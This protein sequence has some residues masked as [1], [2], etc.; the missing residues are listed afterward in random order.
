ML[1]KQLEKKSAFLLALFFIFTYLVPLN[2]RLLWQPDETR[3]AEISREMLQ[4]GNWIVPYL[5]NIRYFEKPVAGYWINNISQ[6]IFGDTNFAVRFGSVFTTIISAGLIYWL[7]MIIWRNKNISFVAT[8]IY[9][10]MFLVFSIGTYSV[11][12]PIFTM[13]LTACMVCCF[14][15]LKTSTLFSKL[16]VWAV[17][18]FTC[19][20]AFMTKGFLG[21]V[22]PVIVMLP[23]MIH[24]KRFI[25]TIKFGSISII[26]ASLTIFPWVLIINKYEPDYWYYFLWVEHIHRFL[27]ENAQHKAPFWF[28]IPII[29]FGVIPW[30]GLLPGTLFKSW[31]KRK[32]NPEM[33]FLLCW[34]ILPFLFFSMAKGKLLTYILPVMAPLALMMAKY[35][36]DCLKDCNLIAFKFNGFINIVFGMLAMIIFIIKLLFIDYP[37]YNSTEWP[38]ICL[39]ISVFF[40][41]LIIGYF[42]MISNVKYWLLGAACSLPL[43]L[44]ISYALPEN[45]IDFKLPQKLIRQNIS[46]LKKSKFILVNNVGLGTSLAW[47]LHRSDIYLY[48]KSGELRYGLNYLDSKFRL[49]KQKKFSNWLR[50]SRKEGQISLVLLLNR[51]EN[52][53]NNIP[54]YDN[55]I[56]NSRIAIITYYY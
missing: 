39:G 25:E 1:T 15:L 35:S 29:L 46:L 17:M 38:K 37:L 16:F 26:S 42:S 28:Y 34:F 49:I 53:P 52:L 19:G 5:L 21:L 27:S 20:M 11:L 33:F 51:N 22:I 4:R 55:V 6:M 44:S 54:E 7:G 56:R 10:S 30:L 3:Y 48:E 2:E 9:L 50:K 43:S 14:F 13:W 32:I 18:G 47:E 23:V 8:L 24:Q 31:K 40:I 12:D 36:I 45:I 41:W